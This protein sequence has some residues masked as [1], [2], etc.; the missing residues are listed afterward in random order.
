M[1]T[2]PRALESVFT[3]VR[4]S[5]T[6][7]KLSTLRNLQ[8]SL[9]SIDTDDLFETVLCDNAI[10]IT[11]SDMWQIKRHF[12]TPT[13]LRLL[14]IFAGIRG[15]LGESRKNLITD[16]FAH[17]KPDDQDT[18]PLQTIFDTYKAN[19]NPRVTAGLT[20]VRRAEQ[21]FQDAFKD[22]PQ[23]LPLS[24]FLEAFHNISVYYIDDLFQSFVNNCFELQLPKMEASGIE[25]VRAFLQEKLRNRK[26]GNESFAQT[27]CRTFK[28][29]DL[30]QSGTIDYKEF[31][32]TFER[33]GLLLPDEMLMQLYNELDT[34]ASKSINY[35]EFATAMLPEC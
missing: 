31:K 18:I 14:D 20:T 1:E 25:N 29:F 26:R 17:L 34:D 24:D 33:L 15:P 6:R 19:Q 8:I 7:L 3:R 5:L 32:K 21:E 2:Y 12:Q 23:D 11:K 27:L 9:A 22:Y 28:F 16:L 4:H 35:K 13:G 10:F 30:D